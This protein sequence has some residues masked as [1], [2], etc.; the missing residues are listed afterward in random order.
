MSKLKSEPRMFFSQ[1]TE[2]VRLLDGDLGPVYR[3]VVSMSYED[4]AVG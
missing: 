3:A 1:Q 2:L 4:E